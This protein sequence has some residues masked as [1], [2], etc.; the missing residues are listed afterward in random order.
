ME[1]SI[2][3]LSRS[4]PSPA[5]CRTPSAIS[6]SCRRPADELEEPQPLR[7]RAVNTDGSLTDRDQLSCVSRLTAK[8]YFRENLYSFDNLQYFIVYRNHCDM[9]SID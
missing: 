8:M 9:S 7:V 4:L 5:S 6:K 3:G 1:T 2:R